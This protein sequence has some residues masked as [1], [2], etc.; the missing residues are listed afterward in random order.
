VDRFLFFAWSLTQH[1]PGAV[2]HPVD[3]A[4]KAEIDALD[5]QIS[6]REAAFFKHVV[7]D[8]APQLRGSRT[9]RGAGAA[10]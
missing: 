7:N 2:V 9:S 4:V 3:A 5:A 6:A 8:I 10:V 1:T